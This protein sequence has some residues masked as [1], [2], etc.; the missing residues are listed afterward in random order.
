MDLPS[1]RRLG[2]MHLVVPAF[3][4]LL[5]GLATS[6][7]AKPSS[8]TGAIDSLRKASPTDTVRTGGLTGRLQ[9]LDGKPLEFAN[10]LLLRAAD[11]V[12]V[13]ATLS[14]AQGRFALADVPPGRYRVRARQL[15]YRD[16]R[17]AVVRVVGGPP[18]ALPP[19]VLA[20]AA[21]ALG[22]V[23]VTGRKPVIERQIDRLIV[24]V[25]Q[26]PAVAGGSA[27]DVIK[28]TPG[29]TVSATDAIGMQGKSGVLVLIDDRPVR[30]SPDALANMLR[31]MPAESIQTLEVITTP[32]A[33]YDA[34]GNAGILNI[35]TRQ[36]Q[37]P[38]WNTDLTLRGAQGHYS[39]YS[40][41]AVV[42]IKRK[43]IDLNGSYFLGHTRSFEDITQ[44]ATQRA[45]GQAP[46]ELR[47]QSHQLRLAR[48]HDAKAQLDVKTGP[49]SSAGL[50]ANLY[51]LNNPAEGT[52]SART[53]SSGQP[54]DTTVQIQSHLANSS[55]NYSVDGYYTVR[56]DSVGKTVSVD[57]NYARFGTDQQQ[58]F[59]NQTV[60][61]AR[62][63]PVGGPQQLRSQLAGGTFIHSLK[64]D[65]TLP[66]P[67]FKLETGAKYSQVEAHNDFRF[68]RAQGGDFVDDARRTNQFEYQE[69]IYAA[70]ASA[71]RDWAKF[72]AQLGLRTEY[73]RTL[74]T[75]RTTQV[76][77]RNNYF[78]LFPTVY[79]Q[80]KF[81]PAYQLNLSYSRRVERPAYSSL[82]P[83][84]SYQS[85]YFSNQGN[86]FLQPSFTDAVEWTNVFAHDLSI[87]PFF[88]YTRQL[89][90]EYPL[91]NLA[92]RETT[93]T[94]GNLGSSYNYG[95]TVIAPFTLGKRWKV[96]NNL[97]VYEQ[98][99]RS[100]L[101]AEPQ[102]S[103][104]FVVNLNITN[105]FT[106]TPH[107]TAQLGG[108]YNSP[109]IQ[110]FYRSLSYY[111]LNTGATLKMLDNKAIL[112]LSL[113]DLLYTERG[114][115]DVHYASQDF[116]FYRRNDTWLLRFSFTYK[117]GNTGLAR[118]SQREGAGQEER[119]RAN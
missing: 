6:A 54:T 14:D 28:S 90:S 8:L 78:Q 66:F 51:L 62:A 76:S 21:Q 55:F 24:N 52:G 109:T 97:T 113:A 48:Y 112:S 17:S 86:P 41:G 19:L 23:Q 68:Q 101:A 9:S 33:K 65:V 103:H 107:L 11:S 59:A 40:G 75:S 83:F 56:L 105:S 43:A 64:A 18:L 5:P 94:Y 82:N 12:L 61:E 73:T 118:K 3:L 89:A 53:V 1:S 32:P 60:D 85:Q 111:A 93:Y 99:F 25:D 74:G 31:N 37:Q 96:D 36:R 46:S 115:A 69:H 4:G 44:Y 71:S 42:G 91:Q 79:A 114:A 38:G 72:S 29:V 16:G 70:Y 80:Y 30:L 104:V 117:L 102:R 116:G 92:T 35:R 50:V 77:N 58:D 84:L 7:L 47:S 98:A 88:N 67:K 20:P 87:A 27:Y 49:K 45:P 100:A 110:G 81:S 39:R 119:N 63:Q 106:I 108:Y 10:V 13:K 15:G 2:V 57:A 34:E 26:L 95:V 22:E